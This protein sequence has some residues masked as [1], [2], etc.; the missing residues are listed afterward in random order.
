MWLELIALLLAPLWIAVAAFRP[1]YALAIGVAVFLGSL[2]F[3]GFRWMGLVVLFF[4]IL[5]S[6]HRKF[7]WL[8]PAMTIL[9]AP[10]FRSFW[11]RLLGFV[12]AYWM[13]ASTHFRGVGMGQW[14]V[15]QAE[16]QRAVLSYAQWPVW[17]DIAPYFGVAPSL[18]AHLFAEVGSWG[19]LFWIV[20]L[21]LILYFLTP[22]KTRSWAAILAAPFLVTLTTTPVQFFLTVDQA[23]VERC[24]EELISVI[25]FET[26]PDK[27]RSVCPEIRSVEYEGALWLHLGDPIRA[28]EAYQRWAET[29]PNDQMPKEALN[30][31]AIGAGLSF[32]IVR[33]FALLPAAPH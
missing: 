20:P 19:L 3:P 13:A 14:T 10:L 17:N 7:L 27:L 30:R 33:R 2:P 29:Y 1:R 23:K 22:E 9:M 28:Q 18:P 8:P 24:N 4:C 32:F 26:T 5:L 16:A 25:H 11:G 31:R 15:H 6:N 21:F 12:E